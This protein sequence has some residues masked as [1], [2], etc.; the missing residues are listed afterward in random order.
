MFREMTANENWHNFYLG[1]ATG[2]KTSSTRRMT[3][4]LLYLH[5]L[6]KTHLELMCSRDF[7][8]HLLFKCLQ[9]M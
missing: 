8:L 5:F 1:E 4:V 9:D 3:I 6:S 2:G 7:V